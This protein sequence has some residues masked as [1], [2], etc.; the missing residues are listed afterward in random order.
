VS[1][2]QPTIGW[3]AGSVFAASFAHREWIPAIMIGWYGSQYYWH[4]IFGVNGPPNPAD[5]AFDGFPITIH[6]VRV[7]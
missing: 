3:G 1:L 2:P 4:T 7:A 5:V 6:R